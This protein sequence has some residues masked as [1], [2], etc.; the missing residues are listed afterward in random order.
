MFSLKEFVKAFPVEDILFCRHFMERIQEKCKYKRKIFIF[1]PSD[2][3][4]TEN[5]EKIANKYQLL[6]PYEKTK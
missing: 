2:V 3:S 5:S 1:S 6:N 4:Q